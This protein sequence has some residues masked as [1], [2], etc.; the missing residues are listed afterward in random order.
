MIIV[1]GIFFAL[2]AGSFFLILSLFLLKGMNP[3]KYAD[4]E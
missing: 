1:L 3:E 2:S 4:E